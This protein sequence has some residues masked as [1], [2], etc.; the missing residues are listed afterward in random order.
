[1]PG[2][3]VSYSVLVPAVQNSRQ[4]FRC[5]LAFFLLNKRFFLLPYNNYSFRVLLLGTE[6]CFLQGST[7][8]C[9]PVAFGPIP[10]AFGAPAFPNQLPEGPGYSA[11]L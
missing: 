10:A 2:T 1:M 7:G 4:C 3:T 11:V 6:T 9:M 5:P 8:Q